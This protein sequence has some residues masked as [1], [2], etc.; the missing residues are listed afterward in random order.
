MLKKRAQVIIT[1]LF[2]ADILIVGIC[3][4]LAY[5]V[6]FHWLNIPYSVFGFSIPFVDFSN[7]PPYKEYFNATGVVVVV[8]AIC[9]IYGKMYNPSVC[10]LARV[11]VFR[12]HGNPCIS[13]NFIKWRKCAHS[14]IPNIVLRPASVNT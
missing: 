4:N 9:N 12:I 14:D 7:I 6:R 10:I 13:Q 1:L 3:W 5:F 11:T 8:A 2:L